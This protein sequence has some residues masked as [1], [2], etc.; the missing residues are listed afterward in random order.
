MMTQLLTCL[1]GHRWRVGCLLKSRHLFT[2]RGRNCL[3]L[4]HLHIPAMNQIRHELSDLLSRQETGT[5]T[6]T[7]TPTMPFC[8]YYVLDYTGRLKANS[9]GYVRATVDFWE[10]GVTTDNHICL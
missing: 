6:D 3:N 2:V 1:V 5:Q 4:S 8:T 9:P 7:V 10:E